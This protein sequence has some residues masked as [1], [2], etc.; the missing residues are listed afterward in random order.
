MANVKRPRKK[1]ESPRRSTQLDATRLRILAASRKLF[2]H[3][4][5]PS[6]TMGAIAAASQLAVPTVYKNFGNKRRLLLAL[7]EQTIDTRVPA[8]LEAVLAQPTPRGRVAA[9]AEMCVNLASGAADVIS[10]LISA[11][12]ADPEFAE[13]GSRI[14]E[15][16]RRNAALIAKSLAREGA[17]LPGCDEAQARDVMYALAGPEQ[18]E[19]LVIRSGW[20]DAQFETWLSNTLAATLLKVTP[21]DR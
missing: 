16:R 14:A 12:G 10:I 9:L 13:M 2:R 21:A 11:A 19:L 1:Y 15:G 7:I 4:G 8:E 3:R 18:Y 6:T 5:Y 17:L 20:S